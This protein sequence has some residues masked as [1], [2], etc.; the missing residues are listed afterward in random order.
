MRALFLMVTYLD[1]VLMLMTILP[2]EVS[3][4]ILRRRLRLW[5]VDYVGVVNDLFDGLVA[6]AG[7]G[8]C[9]LSLCW[10][11]AGVMM[12]MSLDDCVDSSFLVV[13]VVV[14]LS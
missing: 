3:R 2:P 11:V 10:Q 4:R 12:S 5:R 13:I 14:E 6:V 8:G 7:R 1:L 9:S